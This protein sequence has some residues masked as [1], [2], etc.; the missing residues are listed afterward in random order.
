LVLNKQ[1]LKAW[2]ARMDKFLLQKKFK[3]G[4]SNKN[5]YLRI[6]KD[7]LLVT[8]VYVDDIIFGCNN[9]ESNHKFAQ[10]MSKEFEMS[11]IGEL[12]FFLGLKI[13][14]SSK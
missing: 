13:T 7:Y 11:M 3:R 12:T 14:Q 8:M 1:A 5:I 10:E 9:D 6:E 4:I 2:N